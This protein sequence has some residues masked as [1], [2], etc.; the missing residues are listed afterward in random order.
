MATTSGQASIRTAVR[1]WLTAN[2][3]GELP[4]AP[5]D[6]HEAL[7]DWQRLLWEAG[8]LGLG[9]PVEHGGHGGD[10]ADQIA[11]YQ[12]LAL[13]KAPLPAGL[14][15]LDVIGPT[16][17]EHGSDEQ[18]QRFVRPLLAGDEIWCQAFSEPDAGSDLASLRTTAV[19]EGDEF[20]VNG[21][22]VWTSMAEHAHWCAV[23]V[24]TDADAPRHKG[25]SYLLTP[26]D[27]PGITV[28]P[29]LQITGASEFGEVFFE[30]VRV[31]RDSVLGELNDG[32]RMALATLVH[33]RGIYT[34]RRQAEMRVALDD[35]TAQAATTSRDGRPL[36]DDP[37][38]RRRLGRCEVMVEMM[39]AQGYRTAE[40]A[41]SG[42]APAESSVDKVL[43]AGVEHE[44]L[45][46]ALD[47]LGSLATVARP[48]CL[49]RERWLNDYF[50]SRTA[51]IYGGTG[52][53]QRNIIAT[54]VLGLPRS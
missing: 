40:R 4:T 30:N 42:D 23:L 26:M 22:K 13:A 33:E 32:W 14:V 43:L 21:Q 2:D 27:A 47:L 31:P 3:P 5:E 50:Y 19:L 29:V 16:I 1:E 18:K 8:W 6:R 39:A 38:W 45:G 10:A 51:S 11:V 35:L 15:G 34:L 52:E 46:F 7:R 20:V 28:H 36:L 12:E 48:G 24:R 53:I 41:A 17:V 9:W 25:I 37:V 44:V 54:S 49:D